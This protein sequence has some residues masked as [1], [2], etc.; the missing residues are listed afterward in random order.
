MAASASS[1]SLPGL[2]VLEQTPI[3]VEKI[4]WAANDELMQW[5][6][7]AERWSIGEV[8]AHLADV[9]T[10]FRGRV[11]KMLDQNNPKIEPYDQNASYAAG[12][13][14]GKPRENLKLFCHERDRTLSWLRYVPASMVERTGAHAE[15]GTI[16]VGQLMNEWGFHDMGHI[17]QILELYRAHEFHPNMGAFQKYYRV[18]P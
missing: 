5:K 9:E 1:H 6:P 10:V 18:T 7:T 12:K 3:I 11:Q 16:S 4:L 8:L 17:R 13:Y 14:A 2:A 15:L